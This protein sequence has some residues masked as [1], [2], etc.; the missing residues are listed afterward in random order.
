MTIEYSQTQEYPEYFLIDKTYI[1]NGEA[2]KCALI[3]LNPRA[4]NPFCKT[5]FNIRHSPNPFG[6]GSVIQITNINGSMRN[7]YKIDERNTAWIQTYKYNEHKYDYVVVLEKH[8]NNI[9]VFGNKIGERAIEINNNYTHIE[10][11]DHLLLD[12]YND[13]VVHN[14]TRAKMKY[15]I[16][17]MAR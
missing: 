3:S 5:V 6:F 14:V 1:Y 10:R 15:D 17:R 7:C 12:T 4:Q 11:G 16:Q 13:T 8:A 2:E 9:T